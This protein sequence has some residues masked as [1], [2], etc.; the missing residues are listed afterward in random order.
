MIC[1]LLLLTSELLKNKPKLW[2]SV[3]QAEEN[4]EI[5]AITDKQ[6][7]SDSDSE[8][9]KEKAK[10]KKKVEKKQEEKK[11]GSGLE[12]GMYD[13][14]KRDPKF[15]KAEDSCLWEIVCILISSFQHKF[16]FVFEK[17]YQKR[18]GI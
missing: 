18:K 14:F 4:N 8:K 11:K 12:E 9:E 3:Q 16:Q 7:N 15:A 2:T 17:R 5:P 1:G 13:A 10:G 6:Y